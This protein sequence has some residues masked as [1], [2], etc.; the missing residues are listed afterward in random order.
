MKQWPKLTQE[1]KREFL[2]MRESG[3]RPAE[4]SRR[5]GIP[6]R[7]IYHWTQDAQVKR[8]HKRMPVK[9]EEGIHPLLKILFDQIM[10]GPPLYYVALK[11]GF[12]PQTVAKWFRG[13]QSPR[14]KEIEHILNVLGLDIKWEVVKKPSVRR[15]SRD[16]A[17]PTASA[18]SP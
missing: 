1:Q 5:T 17:S 13:Q 6:A 4:I 9:V 7:C 12:S 16:C 10:D 2:V 8:G 15:A 11:S 3:I 18:S 14:L